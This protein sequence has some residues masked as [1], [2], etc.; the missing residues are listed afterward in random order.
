[1][2]RGSKEQ[3]MNKFTKIVVLSATALT[4]VGVS[5]AAFAKKHEGKGPMMK[6]EQ[7]DANSDGFVTKEEMQAKQA[8][9][10]ATA[11]AD[12]DGFLTADELMNAK[13]K[14]GKRG[15]KNK[16]MSENKKT[17]ML[18][19]MDENGDGK[20]ALSEMPTDRIDRMF[21]R[22]DTNEDGKISKEEMAAHKGKRGMKNK[23]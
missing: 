2:K 12:G 5:G 3:K 23:G 10:F 19:Y 9:R 16:E 22:L 8:E 17:R 6:F 20:V 11:D 21:D 1:M 13:P 7:L 15:G 18:R 14:M 4:L